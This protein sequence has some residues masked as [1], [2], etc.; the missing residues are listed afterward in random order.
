M[1][2]LINKIEVTSILNSL[3]SK[4]SRSGKYGR[5]L[6]DMGGPGDQG[7][8]QDLGDFAK[9]AISVKLEKCRRHTSG[10]ESRILE[11]CLPSKPAKKKGYRLQ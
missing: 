3:Q 6:G 11:L 7:S 5:T 10:G 4:K 9:L 1:C 8:S 2:P